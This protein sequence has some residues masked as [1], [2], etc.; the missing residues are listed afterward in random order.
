MP[1]VQRSANGFTFVVH[2]GAVEDLVL[3]EEA[4]GERRAEIAST[5][6]KKQS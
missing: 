2:E 3:R 6:A 4:G 5:E 1:R